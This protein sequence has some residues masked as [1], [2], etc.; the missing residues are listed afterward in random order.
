MKRIFK[1]PLE[2]TDQQVIHMPRDAGPLCVQV[3]QSGP[4]LWAMVDDTEPIEP[5]TV[6]VIGTGHPIP[7]AI[8]L[9]YVGTYQLCG[10]ALVFH[11]FMVPTGVVGTEGRKG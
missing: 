5:R 11:V 3:Q 4:C 2:T 6:R 8:G 1:Y 7:D 9:I 10:G